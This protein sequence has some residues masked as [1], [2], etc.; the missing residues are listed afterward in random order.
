MFGGLALSGVAFFR[1]GRD[2]PF[3][4]KRTFTVPVLQMRRVSVTHNMDPRLR[5]IPCWRCCRDCC[6]AHAPSS[7]LN[8]SRCSA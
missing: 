3:T 8:N 7:R 1:P 6:R 2:L 4:K 5:G